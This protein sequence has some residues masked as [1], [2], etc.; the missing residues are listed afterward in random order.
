MWFFTINTLFSVVLS[1][2]EYF[3][4]NNKIAALIQKLLF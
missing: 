1:Y 2:E 3:D 4:Y